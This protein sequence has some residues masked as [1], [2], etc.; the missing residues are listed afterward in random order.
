MEEGS[1]DSD[2]EKHILTTNTLPLIPNISSLTTNKSIHL[3]RAIRG[4]FSGRKMFKKIILVIFITY[5]L[6]EASL[7]RG[8]EVMETKLVPK[9][10][11]VVTGVDKSPSSS[12]K[13]QFATQTGGNIDCGI[14]LGEIDNDGKLEIVAASFDQKVYVLNEDG[15][16]VSGWPVSLP[17][18]WFLR[19]SPAIGDINND[20]N[21]EIVVGTLKGEVYALDKNG[22]PLPYWPVKVSGGVF[23]P[24]ALA[25]IDKDGKLE[26]IIGSIGEGEDIYVYVFNEDGTN[27]PGWP[28]KINATTWSCPS[29]GD[30]NRDGKLEIGI[31]TCSG[32]TYLWN[33]SGKLL[34]TWPIITG[35]L[36][37]SST[38]F[39]NI[40][41]DKNLEMIVNSSDKKVY[42]FKPNGVLLSGW[43]IEIEGSLRSSPA[44]G[45]INEDGKLEIIINSDDGKVYIFNGDGN[46]VSGWPVQID[47]AIQSSPILG[48]IDK[49][50]KIEIIVCST[51]KKVY[52]FNADGSRVSG[53]PL[54]T[55]GA[56]VSTPALGNIDD[57]DSLELIVASF[58]MKIYCW[59]LGEGTYMSAPSKLSLKQRL[60]GQK[61]YSTK[62]P[63]PMF[64]QNSQ[65]TGTYPDDK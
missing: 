49:D 6:A 29:I 1:D 4:L 58:D 62:L 32:S 48:D 61:K 39:G 20:G 14:A 40:D 35:F 9:K 59:D 63:W 33:T 27:L 50:G 38:V 54:V 26:V 11:V 52:A 17:Q 47:G 10:D 8:K 44:L 15:N 7:S 12:I 64:Q 19:S 41:Q 31:T 43:P 56:I 53:F 57:D 65:H 16:T 34:P 23:S 28:A 46:L 55:G 51:D 45:D 60:F 13:L 21:L 36:N 25:D 37:V 42:A 30:I 5:L 24:P 3:I 22:K 18:A 2:E